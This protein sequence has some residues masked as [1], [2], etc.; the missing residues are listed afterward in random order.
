MPTTGSGR[1]LRE[2]RSTEAA[3]A[4]TTTSTTPWAVVTGGQTGAPTIAPCAAR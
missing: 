3:V 1:A 4:A 2:L